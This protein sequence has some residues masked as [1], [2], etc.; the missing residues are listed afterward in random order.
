MAQPSPIPR[1]V[2]SE[3][4]NGLSIGV[5]YPYVGVKYYFNNDFGVEA[6]F[7]NG[8]GIDLYSGRGYW[9]FARFNDF[10]LLAGLDAGYIDFTSTNVNNVTTVTGNGYEVSP[11]CGA[12]YF[13]AR[14]LSCM[15]DFAMPFI[16]LNQSHTSITDLEWVLNAGVYVYPF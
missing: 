5:G 12:E 4:S 3:I 2:A 11:F 8:E 9:S 15:V 10:R 14:E 6:R 1:L 7:A 13:I 16:G